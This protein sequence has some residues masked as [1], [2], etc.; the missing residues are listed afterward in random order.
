MIFRLGGF[1]PIS[2]Y[3]AANFLPGPSVNLQQNVDLTTRNTFRLPASARY[4][5]AAGTM[6][7]LLEGLQFARD[8]KLKV[9][10]LG[11]GSNLV[12]TEDIDG[13]MISVELTGIAFDQYLV[14]AGA[15]ENWHAL[16]ELTLSKGLFG[17]EN[18]AL[19]PGRVGAAPMQNIGAYGVELEQYVVSLTAV[20]RGT[21]EIRRFSC[22]DCEFG[23]RDSVFKNRESDQWIITELQLRLSGVDHPNTDYADLRRHFE[24]Q[25]LDP[26]ARLV[27][28]VVTRIRRQ[29]LPDPGQV[30]NVGSFFKN[31]V[32]PVEAVGR[33]Q[34]AFPAMPMFGSP[35]AI[36]QPQ[37]YQA[38]CSLAN[39]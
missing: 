35:G 34:S 10:V 33:L 24:E 6:T 7:E 18:L 20:H 32:V 27:A 17:L 30:A 19:I 36:K 38:V 16:V 14:R 8:R 5:L 4:F 31:P 26:N 22:K 13:L 1:V 11:G 29:K 3:N 21:F 12:L 9:Y 39:R 2:R 37:C 25:Q 28:E 15:G 23:Y